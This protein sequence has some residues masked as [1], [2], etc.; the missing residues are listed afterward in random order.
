MLALL[1]LL[2][3]LFLLTLSFLWYLS[4]DLVITWGG[5]Q[6]FWI[7]R[8]Q[9]VPIPPWLLIVILNELS[10]FGLPLLLLPLLD[11]LQLT[12]WLVLLS[13]VDLILAVPGSAGSATPLSKIRVP[14]ILLRRGK[15]ALTRLSAVSYR[16]FSLLLL[17]LHFSLFSISDLFDHLLLLYD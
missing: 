2:L 10:Q 13:V 7:D 17:L 11:N 5:Y 16:P 3:F 14:L 9:I 12:I 4:L 8:A 15:L 1:R 6:F